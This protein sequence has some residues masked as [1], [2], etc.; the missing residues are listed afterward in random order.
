MRLSTPSVNVSD[1]DVLLYVLQ[2]LDK[3]EDYAKA[4]VNNGSN[5]INALHYKNILLKAQKIRK[6]Y[7][8]EEN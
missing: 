2:H 6:E 3:V 5:S 4:Q 7:N 1:T 8:K